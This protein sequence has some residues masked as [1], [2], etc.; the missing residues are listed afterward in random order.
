MTNL[1][2]WDGVHSLTNWVT[3]ETNA[4]YQVGDTSF[5]VKTFDSSGQPKR[6]KG[7]QWQLGTQLEDFTGPC[8]SGNTTAVQ[9]SAVFSGGFSYQTVRKPAFC[10]DPAFSALMAHANITGGFFTS[11]QKDPV[12]Q[13]H[14][15]FQCVSTGTTAFNVI[16]GLS[17]SKATMEVVRNKLIA[18]L[19]D[20][21]QITKNAI[22]VENNNH[23]S[24]YYAH[25]LTQ[26]SS[27]A[28]APPC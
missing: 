16:S 6:C 7:L 13:T 5:R 25:G 21:Y 15:S 23:T 8:N 4:T 19:V 20:S 3:C 18:D 27:H 1:S 22:V 2:S 24:I 12:N 28:D 9:W 11:Y 17:L 14:T 10:A 26:V